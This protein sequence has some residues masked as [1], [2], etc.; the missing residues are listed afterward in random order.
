MRSND[1]LSGSVKRLTRK[2][3]RLFLCRARDLNGSGFPNLAL[4]HQRL[5]KLTVDVIDR[6]PTGEFPGILSLAPI[7]GR[8]IVARRTHVIVS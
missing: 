8:L 1:I 6:D 7:L 3:R 4:L 2:T 5:Q